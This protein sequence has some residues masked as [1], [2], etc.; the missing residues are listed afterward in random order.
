MAE[1]RNMHIKLAMAD[2]LG[3]FVIAWLAFLTAM[4]GFD[5]MTVGFGFMQITTWGGI[6]LLV[7]AVVAF[8]NE[9]ILGT[10]IFGSLGV[11]FAG[12]DQMLTLGGPDEY[13]NIGMVLL[14]L[15]VLF[16]VNTIVSLL[17]P[18]KFLPIVLLL[19][20][21]LFFFLGLW[22]GATT[23]DTYK[24]LFAVFAILESITALY[25]GAAV[26]VLVVKGKP[27]LPLLIKS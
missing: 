9:N 16:L 20:A 24:T 4:F 1:E 8:F 7:V 22:F 6:V 3:C 18:V 17:Q 11:F 2:V 19:A 21:L 26:A 23:N 15:G 25:L 27:L 13:A 14:F 5:Q 10:M 12:F